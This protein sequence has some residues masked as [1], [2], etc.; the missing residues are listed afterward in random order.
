MFLLVQLVCFVIATHFLELLF[1]GVFHLLFSKWF[2]QLEKFWACP[3]LSGYIEHCVETLGFRTISSLFGTVTPTDI[4]TQ[5]SLIICKSLLDLNLKKKTAW[6]IK[7]AW[8]IEFKLFSSYTRTIFIYF[9][10]F[11][12]LSLF[13]FFFH[14]LLI[15]CHL[16]FSR[17][18]FYNSNILI[19]A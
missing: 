18:I 16:Y 7:H 8:R 2:S 15:V 19:V 17:S 5:K 6:I 10:I 13:S 3:L 1:L 14:L 9:F 12:Q 11:F 4:F